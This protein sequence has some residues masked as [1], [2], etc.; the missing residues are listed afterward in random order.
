MHKTNL[1]YKTEIC[2]L[3]GIIKKRCAVSKKD[4]DEKLHIEVAYDKLVKEAETKDS[5]I[6][7]LQ[8]TVSFSNSCM[9]WF[10]E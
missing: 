5:I 6:E 8:N 4:H 10:W 2:D 7:E 3:N 1:L 9:L